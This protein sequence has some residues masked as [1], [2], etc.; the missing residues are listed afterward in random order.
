MQEQE[1]QIVLVED[2][3]TCLQG[4]TLLF[5]ENQASCKHSF[6]NIDF[7]DPEIE[8]S[9]SSKSLAIKITTED[10]MAIDIVN[11]KPSEESKRFERMRR[12][13]KKKPAKK[14]KYYR[15]E[16]IKFR[17]KQGTLNHTF[18]V[19]EDKSKTS[20][21]APTKKFLRALSL[22]N[23]TF[24]RFSSTKFMMHKDKKKNNADAFSKKCE[25]DQ[26]KK[27]EI[28][29][30]SCVDNGTNV[31]TKNLPQPI[32]TNQ[33]KQIPESSTTNTINDNSSTFEKKKL[34]LVKTPCP[35]LTRSLN[36]KETLQRQATWPMTS[37]LTKDSPKQC[38]WP[39][40]KEESIQTQYQ[41]GDCTPHNT[42]YPDRS[43][44]YLA[45]G[46]QNQYKVSEKFQQLQFD[47]KYIEAN[48]EQDTNNDPLSKWNNLF[49]QC[50]F[51][52][53]DANIESI[54]N[55]FDNLEE[56]FGYL[57]NSED[58]R[59]SNEMDK[60]SKGCTVCIIL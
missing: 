45:M 58:L 32:P 47:S 43:K 38:L 57:V 11:Y 44:N 25:K 2:Y 60:P 12:F 15:T 54:I 41:F 39:I 56:K 30:N 5:F 13:N 23:L 7:S 48:K 34:N 29:S 31:F 52:S 14:S 36:S 17:P 42:N 55:Q 53:P 9:A 18:S 22:G 21:S 26:L 24:K 6:S 10:G 20:S 49:V 59:F 3:K 4:T 46:P 35:S 40:K 51:N 50:N 1:Q 37:Y 28:E 16:Q 33:A 19:D 27:Y 8:S